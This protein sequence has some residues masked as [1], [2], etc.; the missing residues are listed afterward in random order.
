MRS[1]VLGFAIA[2]ILTACAT[3]AASTPS[4]RVLAT[5]EA[6]VMRDYDSFASPPVN[7]P[8]PPDS[9]YP[10]L[11]AIYKELGIEIEV[12]DPPRGEIG[13]KSFSKMYRLG[14]TPLH[15][16]VG[17]GSTMTG[18]AADSYRVQMSLVTHLKVSATGTTAQT[19]LTA[20]AADTGSSKGWISCLSTGI[21]EARVNKALASRHW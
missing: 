14:S 5:S 13:N 9:V 10:V 12:Y 15:E 6:G 18:P 8:A 2:L 16:F 1:G 7:I 21:L 4:D 19:V 3:S 11:T 17:C 20:R